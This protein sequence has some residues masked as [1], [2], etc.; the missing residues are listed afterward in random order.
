VNFTPP[1]DL[2]NDNALRRCPQVVI[3]DIDGTLANAEHRLHLLPERRPEVNRSQAWEE[4]L[5]EAYADAIN[6]E[7][8]VLNNALHEHALIFV[9]TG[10]DARDEDMTRRWLAEHCIQFDRLYMRPKGDRRQDTEVKA[11]ILEQIRAEGFE[12]LLAVEDRAS[13]TAMWRANGVRCLQVC[14]GNY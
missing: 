12:V 13:V 11:E 3:M 8:R 6:H 4:F 9:V 2:L 1:D 14:E 10:R 5:A 7:I